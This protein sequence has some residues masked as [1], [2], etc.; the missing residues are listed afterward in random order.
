MHPETRVEVFLLGGLFAPFSD[1]FYPVSVLP[2][3]AQHISWCL[4][5]TYIFEGVRIILHKG[6]FPVEYFL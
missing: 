3:W 6:S 4:P 1:V 5:T 2:T